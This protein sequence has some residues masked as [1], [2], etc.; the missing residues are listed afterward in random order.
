M[1]KLGNA[2][3]GM[4]GFVEE[5]QVELKKCTW[6][7]QPELVQSTVVVIVSVVILSIVVGIS[8]LIL[9]V[10]SRTIIG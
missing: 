2:M 3:S 7:T 10:L 6:P 9:M 5:V 8:D 4:R 1:S